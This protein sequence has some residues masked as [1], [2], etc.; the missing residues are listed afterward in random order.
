VTGILDQPPGA[1]DLTPD[2]LRGLKVRGITTHGE[3]NEIEAVN[4]EQGLRWLDKRPKTFDLLTDVAARAVHLRLFGD[5]WDWAGEYRRTEKYI[6]VDIWSISTEM[7]YCMDDAKMWCADDAYPLAELLARFHHRL[8]KIHPYPNGNGRWARI[9]TDE[10]LRRLD[11][12]RSLNWLNNGSLQTETMHRRRYI[13]AL[14]H[15]DEHDFGSITAFM[16]EIL[17]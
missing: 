17:A 11:D 16:R 13:D 8:V 14:R 3:L 9:M 5:V 2:E 10:L 4:I 15:A 7:R 6:G 12:K 1:T